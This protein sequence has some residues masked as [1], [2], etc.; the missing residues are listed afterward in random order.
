[1]QHIMGKRF[2]WYETLTDLSL[3]PYRESH[4]RKGKLDPQG[5]L[6]HR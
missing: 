3:L 1:M 4:G 2:Q 5:S 6:D